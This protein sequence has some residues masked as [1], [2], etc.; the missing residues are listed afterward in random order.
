MSG[1]IK[2]NIDKK[3]KIDNKLLPFVKQ[4]FLEIEQTNVLKMI[5]SFSLEININ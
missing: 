4:S 3:N 1:D 2:D 5:C